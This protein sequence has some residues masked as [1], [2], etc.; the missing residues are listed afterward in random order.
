MY[1]K[2]RNTNGKRFDE[3][4]IIDWFI[5][6]ALAIYYMHERRILHRDLKTQNIFLTGGKIRLGDFGISKVLDDKK[7]LTETVIGTPYYMSP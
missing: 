1:Q 6:M 4:Q 2:I 3:N 7:Q 5:Q